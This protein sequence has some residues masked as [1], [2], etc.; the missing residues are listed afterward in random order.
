MVTAPAIAMMIMSGLGILG[1]L[2]VGLFVGLFVVGGL[3]M[4]HSAITPV[5]PFHLGQIGVVSGSLIVVSA[6]LGL[7][8]SAFVFFAGWRM[9]TLRNRGLA[10]AGSIVL[11]VTGLLV[12][13][14]KTPMWSIAEIA[15][16]V[17]ALVILLRPEVSAAFASAPATP[18]PRSTDARSLVAVPAGGLMVA[19]ALNL[20]LLGVS[21]LFMLFF[22]SVSHSPTQDVVRVAGPGISV[23]QTT[24]PPTMMKG[25]SWM[26]FLVIG[27]VFTLIPSILTFIGA[28]RMRQLRGYGLAITAAIL[29]IITPPGMI[30]GVI[31]GIWA[32]AVLTRGEVRA[33]FENG[34]TRSGG[35]GCLIAG[36]TFVGLLLVLA[37]GFVGLKTM[38]S[39]S[40]VVTTSAVEV[41]YRA[42][43]ADA[44]LVEKLVPEKTR[45]PGEMQDSEL[46]T[47]KT[48][49]VG[50]PLTVA[51]QTAEVSADVLA[52]LLPDASAKLGVL[53]D[54]DRSISTWPRVSDTWGY[55]GN[56]AFHGNLMGTGFVGVRS[57][58][59]GSQLRSDYRITYRNNTSQYVSAQ[60]AWEGAA[61]QPG[62]A[63]TFFL[64]FTT[65][66]GKARFVVIAFEVRPTGAKMA[67][68]D[69]W[70]QGDWVFDTEY[71][72]EKMRFRNP[73]DAT[74]P[75]TQATA[76]VMFDGYEKMS[77]T[78]TP[79]E[80]QSH[81]SESGTQAGPYRIVKMLDPNAA[82]I[83]ITDNGT[84]KR[85]VFRREG[86]RLLLSG[87][88]PQPEA[89]PIDLPSYYKRMVTPR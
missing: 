67:A 66:D 37:L 3:T 43:E 12:I 27:L 41:R 40:S 5:L 84:T 46:Q 45:L 83:E 35:R 50:S 58:Q 47:P 42:F 89:T 60:I 62:G 82:E 18:A 10:L 51:S 81:H 57:S 32:L 85:L 75:G 26:A 74:N 72:R 23:S 31:F 7:A 25:M 44:A 71:S 1:T 11:I 14:S 59:G 36:A 53:V 17:W 65:T 79:T 86:D 13:A 39:R 87:S 24:S 52:R 22:V 80:M 16:G 29:G 15:I 78:I 68:L 88:D 76:K 4:A 28:W 48:R 77:W 34:T 30:I 63:R 56:D 38:R 64:P 49:L 54:K 73:N 61:P 33:A 6:L 2:F 69:K 8:G 20:L 19:S 9:R 21:L 70:I 55:N